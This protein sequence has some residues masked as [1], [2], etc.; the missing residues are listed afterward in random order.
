[1]SADDKIRAFWTRNFQNID[2]CKKCK[3]VTDII[4]KFSTTYVEQLFALKLTV[5]EIFKIYIVEYA[6]FI[7]DTSFSKVGNRLEFVQTAA[8][9][10]IKLRI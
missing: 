2:F 6:S 7:G 9:Q 4:F 3:T 8:S 5:S 1:M 10:L